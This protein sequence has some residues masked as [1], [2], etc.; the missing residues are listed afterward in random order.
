MSEKSLSEQYGIKFYI[1]TDAELEVEFQSNK[2]L[3]KNLAPEYKLP[4]S[5][6]EYAERLI[7]E[8]KRSIELVAKENI[9]DF[10]KSERLKYLQKHDELLTEWLDKLKSA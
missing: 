2:E 9:P 6:V 3:N 8:N 7:A 1:K 5:I 10:I 4:E